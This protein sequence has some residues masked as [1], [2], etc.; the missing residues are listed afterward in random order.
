MTVVKLYNSRFR[1][2]SI[3]FATASIVLAAAC[4]S[5]VALE[6]PTTTVPSV[7]APRRTPVV[8][9]TNADDGPLTLRSSAFASN[10]LIPVNFSC[11]G[12]NISPPL[13]WRGAVPRGTTTWAI[14]MQDLDVKPGPWIQWVVT[15]IPVATRSVSTGQM[16]SGS[17]AR[18]ASNKVAAFVGMCPPAGRIHQYRFT[19]YA[20]GTLVA[21]PAEGVTQQVVA[22]IENSAIGIAVLTGHFAR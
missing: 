1:L 16:A 13:T 12:D 3:V 19:V 14:I 18:P 22:S 20:E 6:P 10:G 11:A 17:I 7:L 9:A 2:L 8:S 21:L 15:G 5:G 4:T